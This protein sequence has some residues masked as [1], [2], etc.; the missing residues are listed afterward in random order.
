MRKSG[1]YDACSDTSDIS[2]LLSLP[3]R[4]EGEVVKISLGVW[5]QHHHVSE[6]LEKHTPL[7]LSLV[8]FYFFLVRFQFYKI[9]NQTVYSYRTRVMGL[10]NKDEQM[11]ME[12]MTIF[13]FKI[14]VTSRGQSRE[15]EDW[16]R[17]HGQRSGFNGAG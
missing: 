5:E 17:W 8:S 6:V 11:R 1:F 13:E 4:N 7:A 15:W 9:Q 2:T 10:S 16:K 3:F 14:A 12:R